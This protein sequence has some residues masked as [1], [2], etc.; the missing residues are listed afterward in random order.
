[1]QA[2]FIGKDLHGLDWIDMGRVGAEL[3]ADQRGEEEEERR[4]A[5]RF[6]FRIDPFMHHSSIL[7]YFSV[8]FLPFEIF[9]FCGLH[10]MH[11]VV[12]GSL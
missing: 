10:Y 1:M 12:R 3:C 4:A 6:D 7:I 8:N 5:P 11:T 2:R 9:R